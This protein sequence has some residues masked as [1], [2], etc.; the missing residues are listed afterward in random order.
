MPAKHRCKACGGICDPFRT[1]NSTTKKSGRIWQCRDCGTEEPRVRCRPLTADQIVAK[2]VA[3]GL[4]WS[5]EH[6]GC[7]LEVRIWNWPAVVGRYRPDT[8][9]P[10]AKMLREALKA[11]DL[12][13][14]LNH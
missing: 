14:I 13:H 7:L 3:E 6:C 4:G 5:I 8:V 9:E 2:L 11:G 1:Y 10:L 12:M